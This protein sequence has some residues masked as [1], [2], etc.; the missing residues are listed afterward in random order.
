MNPIPIL[1]LDF[2]G[3]LHPGSGL[4]QTRF[5]RA[6][7]LEAALAGHELRIVVSSSW[8]FHLAMDEILR[9]L[10]TGL[11]RRVA[12][13]TGEAHIGRWARF[14]EITAWLA[15]HDPLADWRA[16]DD[17]VFEFPEPCPQLIACHPQEGFGAGQALELQKW[18]GQDGRK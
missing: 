16:L 13:A 11:A 5:S 2:D 17:A 9:A 8:R 14:Q 10:P 3:V 12:G 18:L 6:T 4:G 15:L 1:F 7:V